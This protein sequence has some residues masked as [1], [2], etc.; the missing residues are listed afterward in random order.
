MAS[1]D[2]R[3]LSRRS[4]RILLTVAQ[5]KG[6]QL[7]IHKLEIRTHVFSLLRSPRQELLEFPE[8]IV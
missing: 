3:S 1:P 8:L 6:R 7:N 2:R 4:G 5:W